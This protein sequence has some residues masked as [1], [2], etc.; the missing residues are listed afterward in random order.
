MIAGVEDWSIIKDEILNDHRAIFFTIQRA[1]RT[2][3]ETRRYRLCPARF[4]AFSSVMKR[5]S[6]REEVSP[7]EFAGIRKEA[8]VSIGY[9]TEVVPSNKG[10][11]PNPK[12][13]R[14]DRGGRW[15]REVQGG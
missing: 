5:M 13:K 1:H 8:A 3:P 9:L 14:G 7:D 11:V 6:P 2:A 12:V 15:H 4:E 10:V